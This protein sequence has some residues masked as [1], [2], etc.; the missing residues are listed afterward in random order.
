M[1]RELLSL[2]A[3]PPRLPNSSAQK[4]PLSFLLTLFFLLCI[5]GG[6]NAIKKMVSH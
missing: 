5:Y 2:P 6:A 3:V 4:F 1:T